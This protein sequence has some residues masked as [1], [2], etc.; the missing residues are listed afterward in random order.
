MSVIWS[1]LAALLAARIYRDHRAGVI[2]GLLVFSQLVNL[3][4]T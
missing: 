4:L 1:L 3:T 2:V